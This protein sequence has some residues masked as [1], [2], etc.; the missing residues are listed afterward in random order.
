MHEEHVQGGRKERVMGHETL[1]EKAGDLSESTLDMHRAIISL[2]E[3]LEADDWY[4]QRVDGCKDNEL[5]KILEHNRDEE[6]EH[7]AMLIEWIR[8]HDEAFSHEL[9]DYLFT[10]KP[11]TEIEEE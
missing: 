2:I 11:V 5:R 9:K 6:K 7:A 3:E 1:H 8:R 4:N 10:E